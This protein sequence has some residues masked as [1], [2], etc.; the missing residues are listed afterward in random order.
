[1]FTLSTFCHLNTLLIILTVGNC[2]ATTG[3]MLG[4]FKH[5]RDQRTISSNIV[6]QILN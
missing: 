1:M 4:E 6:H 5:R 3:L 2:V